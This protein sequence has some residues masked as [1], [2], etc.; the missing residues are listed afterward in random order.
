VIDSGEARFDGGVT[1]T[2]TRDAIFRV[3]GGNVSAGSIDFPR[4]SDATINFGSG[5][6]IQGGTTVIGSIGLGTANSW[7]VMSVESGSLEVTGPL[8]V[9]HQVTSG[10]GGAF[11][12]TGG[13]LR[14][15]DAEFGIIMSRNPGTNPNNVSQ[16]NFLGGVSTVEKFTL[17]FD[18]AVTAGSATIT[19]NGGSLY[20]G[21][22]GIVKNGSAGLVTNLNFGSG[23]LGAKQAWSTS[24]PITLPAN[25]N[26]SIKAADAADIA[27]DIVLEGALSGEGG[28]SKSGGGRLRLGGANTFG[29]AVGINGG[30]L[31]VSG[32]LGAG[33]EVAINWG[34]VLTGDGT[35]GRAVVL[36]AGGALAPGGATP[37]SVLTAESVKWNAGGVM[38]FKLGTTAN[39]LAVSGALTKE[40]AGV[41]R[42]VL[43]CEEGLAPGRSYTLV[44]FGSTDF[45]AKDFT[46]SGLPRGLGGALRVTPNS[47]VLVVSRRP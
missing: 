47:I 12:V 20:L 41:R 26:I 6:L 5:L 14:V 37:G 46:I 33:A 19:I 28:F 3:R 31:E 38:V 17:G 34:G 1:C 36:N 10:R 18:P 43:R 24:L 16:A 7:G 15:T 13:E 29:G 25:G 45:K 35:I 27:R 2:N 23:L 44:T 8:T 11:R 22:G 32:S 42:L 30:A 21:S 9:G 39:R 4:T 40:G